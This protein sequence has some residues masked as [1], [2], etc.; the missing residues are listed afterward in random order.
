M[1][2]RLRERMLAVAAELDAGAGNEP[3]PAY[4]PRERE[5][6]MDAEG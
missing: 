3:S 5:V 1:H 4:L 2:C 6:H